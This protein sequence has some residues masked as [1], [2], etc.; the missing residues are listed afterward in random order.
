[1]FHIHCPDIQLLRT[2]DLSF[3]L[4]LLLLVPIA[5]LSRTAKQQ[6]HCAAAV[7]LSRTEKQDVA[8]LPYNCR[9]P[10][11]YTTDSSYGVSVLTELF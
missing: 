6:T 9:V 4:L 3:R 10:R 5:L 11:S 7:L 8:L 2:A 1:M